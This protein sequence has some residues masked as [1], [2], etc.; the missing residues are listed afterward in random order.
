MHGS[1]SSE[2][3][4]E[5]NALSTL[6]ATISQTTGWLNVANEDRV[7]G[8]VLRRRNSRGI[9]KNAGLRMRQMR[10]EVTSSESP[11]DCTVLECS[12][13]THGHCVVRGF[14]SR[15]KVPLERS[16]EPR[17]KPRH[18]TLPVALAIGR[19]VKGKKEFNQLL[20]GVPVT[21]TQAFDGWLSAPVWKEG[22]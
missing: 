18:T 13:S 3:T 22:V 9:T 5:Y 20:A 1:F 17:Q 7:I 6:V 16:F 19:K 21:R 15:Q 4:R 8:H 10:T 12:T 11:P 2:F 14:D